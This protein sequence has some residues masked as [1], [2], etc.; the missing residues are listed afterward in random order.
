[1]DETSRQA[2]AT[3]RLFIVRLWREE[4]TQDQVEWRGQVTSLMSG[5]VR[6]FRDPA[7]LY[8]VLLTIM[9]N[10]STGAGP[11]DRCE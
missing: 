7:T 4:L 8:N 6:Y 9:A 10:E 2:T 3:P 5:E 1:M 11:L